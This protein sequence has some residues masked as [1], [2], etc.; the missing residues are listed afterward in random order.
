MIVNG[1]GCRSHRNRG[2]LRLSAGELDQRVDI[3]EA[4]IIGP[5]CDQPDG[6][7]RAVALID[8]EVETLR[9]E[10]SAIVGKK[11]IP[12][13]PGISSSEQI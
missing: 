9:F 4:D 8:G 5:V 10:I 7:A 2:I 6:S 11:K 1:G 12:A 3:S 13:V